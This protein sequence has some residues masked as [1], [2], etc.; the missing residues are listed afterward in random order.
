MQIQPLWFIHGYQMCIQIMLTK[1]KF[2]HRGP[3]TTF[4]TY[5]GHHLQQR[6]VLSFP[7]LHFLV[8]LAISLPSW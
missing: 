4:V 8:T 6:Q 3:S 2:F 5:F 1:I 7:L